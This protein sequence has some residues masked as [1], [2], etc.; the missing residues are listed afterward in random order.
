MSQASKA[1][2]GLIDHT[3][4]PKGL[5]T[6][7]VRLIIP[8]PPLALPLPSRLTHPVADPEVDLFA[9]MKKKK[10]KQVALDVEEPAP[11]ADAA[12]A[13]AP[14]AHP[15]PSPSTSAPA[16]VDETNGGSGTATPVE[17]DKLA[18]DEGDLFADLKK[19]KKKKKDIPMDLVRG[20]VFPLCGR[21]S[22]FSDLSRNLLTSREEKVPLPPMVSMFRSRRR[23]RRSRPR[24][25][26]RSSTSSMPRRTTRRERAT[27]R[28]TWERTCLTTVWLE[29]SIPDET[30]GSSR[31]VI[32]PTP[33]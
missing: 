33:R 30:L 26:P 4:H 24:I 29:R 23:S 2:T 11:E 14:A 20:R 1:H 16:Q 22:Q 17:A 32:L 5:S 18:E 9:G 25:S 7:K 31:A 6:P 13:P 28:A 12:P 8:C 27:S 21:G 15:E 10:K 19:K 3:H